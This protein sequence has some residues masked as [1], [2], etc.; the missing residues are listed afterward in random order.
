VP[1]HL[2]TCNGNINLTVSGNCRNDANGACLG[3]IYRTTGSVCGVCEDGFYGDATD[4]TAPVVSDGRG[5][6]T[7]GCSGLFSCVLVCSKLFLAPFPWC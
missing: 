4:L 7:R 6:L 5:G 3:C 2:C 1:C